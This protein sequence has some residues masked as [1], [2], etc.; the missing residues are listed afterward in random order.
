MVAEDSHGCKGG[1]YPIP[2]SNNGFIAPESQVNRKGSPCIWKLNMPAGKIVN[3]TIYNFLPTPTLNQPLTT[4]SACYEVATI[5]ENS[6][7]K[8]IHKCLSDPRDKNIYVSDGGEIDII[9]NTAVTSSVTG[10]FLLHYAGTETS[11]AITKYSVPLQ[12]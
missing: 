4:S 8:I 12:M 10:A 11:C 6:K 1:H 3:I 5:R 9:F 2:T 7:R